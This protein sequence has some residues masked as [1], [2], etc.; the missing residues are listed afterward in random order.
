MNAVIPAAR[1][2]VTRGLIEFRQTLL[3]AEQSWNLFLAAAFS[4]VLIFQRDNIVEGTTVSLAALTLPS[5]LGMT[6][7][8]SGFIGA[9]SL[10]ST[11][12]EDG[13]L[14]RAKA[15]P[16][17]MTGYLVARLVQVFFDTATSLVV[18]LVP[19]LIL[20]KGLT[21]AGLGGW[22]TLM[23][24]LFLGLLATVPWGVIVG[25]LA[26]SP[27]AAFGYTMLPIMGLTSISGIFYPIT[28]LPQWVQVIGQIFPVYW[29]GLGTRAALLPGSAA[30]A[31][32]GD[33]W[34]TLPTL[35]ILGV[36]AIAG[37]LLA[38]RIL[39]RMARRESG[40]LV[41]ERREQALKRYG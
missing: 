35:A 8:S 26:R 33:S 4:I 19:G 24:V 3:S 20:V 12:R 1:L 37:L 13:T 25:S 9:S 41:Q 14:L 15:V 30:A 5:I 21:D 40:S 6:V 11:H 29:L 23:W 28:A 7:A 17:G 27:Q 16:N 32:I 38:P 36:W 10:L 34:R 31:E 39:R 18:I 2:G 22:L